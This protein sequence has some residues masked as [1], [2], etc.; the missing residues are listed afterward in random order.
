MDEHSRKII[1]IDGIRFATDGNVMIQE[2]NVN[3]QYG[4]PHFPLSQ[5]LFVMFPHVREFI[6]NDI[7]TNTIPHGITTN[8]TK[9]YGHCWFHTT[10][11]TKANGYIMYVKGGA[12]FGG[13]RISD[14]M[15]K[16]IFLAFNTT[17]IPPGYECHHHCHVTSCCNP[18]HITIKIKSQHRQHHASLRRDFPIQALYG[19]NVG[20][21]K[22]S[23][24]AAMFMRDLKS[25]GYSV[26]FLSYIW[27]CH[28]TTVDQILRGES[29]PVDDP[30]YFK[31]MERQPLKKVAPGERKGKSP[32]F[33]WDN[34]TEQDLIKF[35]TS[36]SKKKKHLGEFLKERGIPPK[37]GYNKICY[38]KRKGII[39]S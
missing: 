38:L 26:D 20:V 1:E 36:K 7:I 28:P 18:E 14:S 31:L 34:K 8:K 10:L 11:K 35:Y 6:I 16:T 17:D 24:A 13:F 19:N 12:K 9:A 27:N 25:L 39:K 30:M 15:N 3:D 21:Q 23:S 33:K 29:H 4:L 22:L 37:V 2:K 32:F 5:E